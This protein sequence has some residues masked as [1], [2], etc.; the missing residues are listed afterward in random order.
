MWELVCLGSREDAV[1]GQ[2]PAHGAV[3]GAEPQQWPLKTADSIVQE[4]CVSQHGQAFRLATF[5]EN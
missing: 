1:D 3:H 5:A 2:T 4:W